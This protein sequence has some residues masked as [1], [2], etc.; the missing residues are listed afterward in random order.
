MGLMPAYPDVDL[1]M[2]LKIK[3]TWSRQDQALDL[4]EI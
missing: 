2:K 3:D 4:S 1:K